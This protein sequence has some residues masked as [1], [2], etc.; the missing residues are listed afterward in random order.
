MSLIR[1]SNASNLG[2][3]IR[4]DSLALKGFGNEVVRTLGCVSVDISIDG[5]NAKVP[6]QVVEDRFLETPLLI[7]QSYTEQAHV[8]VYKNTE[9]LHF[10]DISNEMPFSKTEVHNNIALKATSL[11]SINLYGPCSVKVTVQT[12]SE[13]TISLDT[14]IIGKPTQQFVI[15]GG[16]YPVTVGIA[17][18][19]VSPVSDSCHIKE[20]MVV[21]RGVG[22]KLVNRLISPHQEVTEHAKID[23]EKVRV[24]DN[25]ENF[26]REKLTQLLNKYNHCFASS[27]SELGCTNITEMT[28]ELNSKQPVVY[29]PYR[30]SHKERGD[31]REMVNEMLEAGIVRDSVSEYASPIILVRKKDGKMRMCIDYRMLNSLT[32]KERYPM[33]NIEDEIA[34]LSGQAYFITLDLTSGYYQVPISEQSRPLTSFVT[35]DGQYEFNRMPFGLANAPAI[36]QRMMNKVLGSARYNGA[37]AYI[38][39]VLIYG[40]DVEECLSRL[41]TVLQ[42][43]EGANLTL[44]LSKCEF[45]RDKI[46]YL[47]YEISAAGVRPGTKK[48]ECVV[49]FPRPTDLHTVRQFLGLV[50]YFRKF[51]KNFAMLAHPL[52]KLLAKDATWTW[53]E[54]EAFQ[55]LKNRLIT[56]PVLAIY[57]P[58]A[59]TQLH[60][61]ASKL[62]VGGVLLQRSRSSDPFRP[63]AFYSRKTSP[64]EKCFHAY[65]LE[66]LAVICSLKKFRVYLLGLEFKI[67][68][69]CS[70]LR[71]TFS[72]RDILP[73]V[74][75]WWL[76]MQEFQC[77]IEYRPGKSMSHVDALS[78]NPIADEDSK[79]PRKLSICY[80]Y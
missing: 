64:E 36:F 73:R 18:V 2:L 37:T 65:E 29:R 80:D 8:A 67:I 68:T 77:S 28:I 50:S 10:I 9:K 70:A 3:I 52:T 54:S 24:G 27:L 35:P 31:V 61:D 21:G 11:G 41:E 45:L 74:A 42:L 4:D 7:G 56:R 69:D 43:I 49:D 53:A 46:N 1:Q 32:V 14:K 33:P 59:E 78:R 20:G 12:Q 34:R 15:F 26:Q 57:D 76:L 44:N 13:G 79:N 55:T 38:D 5:V 6:C 66:T 58:A 19:Y 71:S 62:G 16:M 60:T 25:I 63:V 39:D 72:K 22:V 48:I 75:R 40:K 51:I 30:L 47:G 23:E 17:H